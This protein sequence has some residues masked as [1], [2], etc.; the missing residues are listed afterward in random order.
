[1]RELFVKICGITN[2]KD[3]LCS[4][5]S[6]AD[7]VGFIFYD[8]SPRRVSVQAARQIVEQLP[9]SITKV[10]VFVNPSARDVSTVC[11]HVK[12]TA[13]QVYGDQSDDELRKLGT[14]VIKAFRVGQDFDVEQLRKYS[15]D[16]F[17]L[18]SFVRGQVGG[19]GET[20]DW[21]IAKKATEHGKVILSGGLNPD[22]VEKAVRFVCPFGVDVCSGVEEVPG[23][24]NF[25]KVRDFIQRAKSGHR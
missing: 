9:E 6:G 8:R 1:V 13:I 12:L 20:F 22:N 18:D 19:T 23:K 2:L 10:G 17:L 21:S 11:Q 24:K 14:S 5:E 4:L 25:R 3:A 7:A 15:V 16:A